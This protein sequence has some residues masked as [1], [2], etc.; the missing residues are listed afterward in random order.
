MQVSQGFYNDW[1]K[2]EGHEELS[3]SDIKAECG[4]KSVSAEKEK[5]VANC[6]LPF[7]SSNGDSEPWIRE[8]Y[9]QSDKSW[10][11]SPT[12]EDFDISETLCASSL[13][14]L[15]ELKLKW[16]QMRKLISLPV[17]IDVFLELSCFFDDPADF[18]NLI[19]G[20]SAFSKTSWNIWKFTVHV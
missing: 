15:G 2:V 5:W 4:G 8:F 3:S 6:G 10:I 20:S 19:S 13:N 9:S 14:Y 1:H 7:T 16:L 18:G 17:K 12:E 11:L